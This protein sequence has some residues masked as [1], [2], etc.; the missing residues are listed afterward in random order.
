MHSL[1]KHTQNVFSQMFS[2]IWL[3][4]FTSLILDLHSKEG[5]WNQV[6][7]VSWGKFC[8][9]ITKGDGFPFEMESTSKYI[10]ILR[11]QFWVVP[12]SHG[13]ELAI[14]CQWQKLSRPHKAKNSLHF[15]SIFLTS[16]L[17]SELLVLQLNEGV[18]SK[19]LKSLEF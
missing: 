8:I 19:S 18:S 16:E 9:V 10:K 4:K 11:P 7:G 13:Q 14:F 15:N 5:Q 6:R 1:V 2:D 3:L 17:V 12:H